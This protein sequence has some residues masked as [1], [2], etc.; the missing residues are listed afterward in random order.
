MTEQKKK[1]KKIQLK[2]DPSLSDLIKESEARNKTEGSIM[3]GDTGEMIHTVSQG[4]GWLTKTIAP[5]AK[6]RAE[7]LKAQIE[8]LKTKSS[9]EDEIADLKAAKAL[10]KDQ[11]K[12]KKSGQGG[13][14]I[15][16]TKVS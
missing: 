9:L 8:K 11:L 16:A 3:E 10:L 15:D 1:S 13:N 2:E 14:N 4:I 5:T 12:R 7:S 6:E